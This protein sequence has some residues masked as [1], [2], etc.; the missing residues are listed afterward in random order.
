MDGVDSMY[1]VCAEG[2]TGSVC[3]VQIDECTSKPC[4]ND[5]TCMD[6]VNGYNCSCTLGYQGNVS[7]I[8]AALQSQN[9]ELK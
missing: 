7:R 6:H 5:A 3:D 4:L 1:C 8:C 9:A 2:Y